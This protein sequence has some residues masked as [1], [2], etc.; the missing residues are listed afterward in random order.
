MVVVMR[1]FVMAL[2]GKLVLWGEAP[3]APCREVGEGQHGQQGDGPEGREPVA[4][5]HGMHVGA[6]PRGGVAEEG[7]ELVQQQRNRRR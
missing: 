2:L 3:I 5:R 6:K 4:V 7:V 1:L